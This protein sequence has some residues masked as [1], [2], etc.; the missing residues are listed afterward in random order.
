MPGS[1]SW[2]PKRAQSRRC[3]GFPGC[4]LMTCAKAD[5]MTQRFQ[6]LSRLVLR[7]GA[8]DL[9]ENIP[10]S[11]VTMVATRAAVVVRRDLHPALARL[12][13]QAL[14]DPHAQPVVDPTGDASLF[15]RAGEFPDPN[16]PEFP[17]SD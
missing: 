5:A 2:V 6:F 10:P 12:L 11:D 16:D 7:E 1:W 13:T 14:I 15:Q 9:S 8:A 17:L 4:G 3:F